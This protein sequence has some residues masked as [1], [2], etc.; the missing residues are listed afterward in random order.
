MLCLV[1]RGQLGSTQ[2]VFFPTA[3]MA[4]RQPQQYHIT[5]KHSQYCI[6]LCELH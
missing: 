6:I 5:D 3:G 4:M 2:T 1:C